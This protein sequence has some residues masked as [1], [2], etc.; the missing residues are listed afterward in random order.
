[1]N[2][3]IENHRR[4]AEAQRQAELASNVEE[5]SF[6]RGGTLARVLGV[7]KKTIHARAEREGWEIR[8]ES[9]R[10]EYN[11][12]PE[13]ASLVNPSVS[14]CS[15]PSVKFTDLPP[16][17]KGR[18]TALLRMEAVS[19]VKR[20]EKVGRG[21]A[22][23]QVCATMIMRHE[24]FNIS[25]R[26]LERWE[27]DYAA[28]GID[29]LV[30]QKLGKVGRKGVEVPEE[31]A[32]LGKAYVLERGSV[33][34]AAREL[35]THPEL[36]AEMRKHLHEGHASKSHVTPSIRAA[37]RVAPLTAALAQGPRAARLSDRFTPGDYSDVKAGDVFVSD[38]MT[39]NVYCWTEWPNAR[40]WIIGQPQVLP[41]LDVGSLRWLNVRVIMRDSGLYTSDDI[42]GLFGDVFDTFGLPR[43]AF[44]LEGG[45]WQSNKV[46]GAKAL[47]SITGVPDVERIGGLASLGIEIFRSY[48]PRSKI[49][50]TCFNQFQYA[51][52]NFPGYAG[53]DQR[54][55]LPEKLKRQLA[56]LNAKH[57]IHHPSEFLPH[58]KQ[59]TGHIDG[60]FGSL[61][62]ERNDGMVL[63]GAAPLEKWME[64][65]GGLRKIPESAKWLYR[66]AMNVSEVTKNGVRISTGTGKKRLTHY[67]DNPALLTPLRGQKVV[68]YWNDRNIEADAC[69]M[70]GVN[71]SRKFIGMAQYVTP[72]GRF[73]ATDEQLDAESQRKKAAMHYSRTELRA[74]QPDMKRTAAPLATDG[75]CR[76]IGNQITQASDR[77]IEK[78]AEKTDLNRIEKKF[79]RQAI[80]AEEEPQSRGDAEPRF[81]PA[82]A[83]GISEQELSE[84]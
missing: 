50:E 71:G 33:A 15:S 55:D 75:A 61:N 82:D 38:D 4:G 16:D 20:L 68:V 59:L 29:G 48:D 9:N 1:M 27:V 62:Q 39:S 22:R 19:M 32:N 46:I 77:A 53:R 36:P 41:V 56:W 35:M 26:S 12:P 11:P 70:A 44:V 73:S 79:Q 3:E 54:H 76:E 57:P 40:G 42:A 10:F 81:A 5:P 67:Y 21:N 37:L 6:I 69:V 74:I 13:I 52:D 17:S 25:T 63:R 72:L 80:Q 8:K 47:T 2:P 78:E 64:E 60:A 24:G 28:H 30:E 83:G 84:L 65:S 45:I 7:D 23:R 34:G 43:Q 18:A 51:M 14:S 58:L 31:F 66:S 49:I